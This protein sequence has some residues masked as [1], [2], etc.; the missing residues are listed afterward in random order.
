MANLAALEQTLAVSFND[1]SLLE[2]SLIHSSYINEN[3]ALT[4]NERL[5]FLGDAILGLVVAQKLYQDFPHLSEGEMTRL[6]SAL[7]R[8]DTLAHIA[9]ALDL[10]SYLYLGK[11]EE[12]SGGRQKAANLAS[13]LEAVMAAVFLDQGL[14]GANDFVLRLLDK[15]LKKA[16]SQ[17]IRA[18]YKSRLQEL[19]QSRQQKTPTYYLVEATGPD[20]ARRFVVE[21]RAGGTVLGQG[22]GR[23]KKAAEMEASR[24]ALEK[25]STNF[26]H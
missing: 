14:A 12:E 19:V 5:E 18:D 15:E 16:T 26:T 13:A 21:V 25:L 11:G 23:S 17:G 22:S 2:G 24:L 6:R 10:G 1:P 4:S 3:P 9:V 8:R 20:H 7:V